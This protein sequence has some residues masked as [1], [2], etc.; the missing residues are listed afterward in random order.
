MFE[1]QKHENALVVVKEGQF[2]ALFATSYED[3][4]S[5]ADII[6]EGMICVK[7]LRKGFN[8][9]MWIW[10]FSDNYNILSGEEMVDPFS[11]VEDRQD[12]K[13]QE[14]TFFILPIEIN[15]EET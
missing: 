5:N 12:F 14:E 10:V 13:S 2:R 11:N 8:K 9:G 1:F 3:V 7:K 6:H 15:E 4:L